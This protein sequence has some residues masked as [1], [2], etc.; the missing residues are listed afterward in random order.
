MKTFS[1]F[2][3]TTHASMRREDKIKR[4]LTNKI[5]LSAFAIVVALIAGVSVI[6]LISENK[7]SEPTDVEPLSLAAV[8]KVDSSAPKELKANF[9][10]AVCSE[11]K[12]T[13]SLLAY[14]TADSEKGNFEMSYIPASQCCEVGSTEG[15]IEEHFKH[16]GS[17]GLIWAVRACTGGAVD[18]YVI[19]DEKNIIDIFKVFGEQVIT[20]PHEVRHAYKGI[21]FIINEGE[22]KLSPDN[23]AKYFSYL[24]DYPAEEKE[25]ITGLISQLLALSM[26]N[27]NTEELDKKYNNLVNFLKTDISAMDIVSYGPLI[28][29]F[30]R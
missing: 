20:V 5:L 10:L 17:D 2:Q 6:T 16:S 7:S 4:F 28:S 24:C 11:E 18:R 29:S 3:E 1:D 27:G 15:S 23:L 9:L 12:R 25:S 8:Q 26:G 14:L 21:S 13:V 19:V 30:V 22:Q